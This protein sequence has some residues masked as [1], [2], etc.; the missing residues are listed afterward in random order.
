MRL[1]GVRNANS[2]GLGGRKIFYKDDNQFSS[3]QE[4]ISSVP[5]IK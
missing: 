1:A 4:T 5:T 3:K 2:D